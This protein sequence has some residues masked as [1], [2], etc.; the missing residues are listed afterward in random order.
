MAPSNKVADT[1][2]RPEAA[3]SMASSSQ[4]LCLACG[5]CCD[6]TIFSS[7]PLKPSDDITPLK[8]VG[9]DIVSDSDANRLFTLPCAA[10]KNCTCTVYANRPQLCRTYKC[11][12]LKRF[13][14]NE[15]PH[16]AA[17]RII[18]KIVSLKNE[19]SALAL[20]ASTNIQS[21]E[22]VTLLMKRW[23]GMSSIG[24]ANQNYADV[25]LKFGALQIYLDR[26][27]REN[28]TSPTVAL[29]TSERT[30]PSMSSN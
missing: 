28:S 24:T 8:T 16:E 5:L 12:L 9:I 21:K 14:R 22:E 1:E 6:G 25:F 26:F 15:I 20:A 11:K 17:L 2:L 10:H 4:S 7:V 3:A 27:V 30:S 13:E 29:G 18:N 19:V 23:W